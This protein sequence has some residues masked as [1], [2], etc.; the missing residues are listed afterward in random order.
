MTYSHLEEF[1]WGRWSTLR[2]DTLNA[3]YSWH[4]QSQAFI[5]KPRTKSDQFRPPEAKVTDT[6]KAFIKLTLEGFDRWGTFS[7][8]HNQYM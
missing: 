3:P 6:A 8:P 1:I 2:L 7:V 4:L 5:S